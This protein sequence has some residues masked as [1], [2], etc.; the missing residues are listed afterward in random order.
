MF[1]DLQPSATIFI[2]MAFNLSTMLVQYFQKR[3]TPFGV[4]LFWR[5][6][7][8]LNW[9]ITVLQTVALPLGYGTIWN[10][11]RIAFLI[12]LERVTRLEL[13]TSTLARWRSTRWATPASWCLRS[14][15]NQRHVD[16]QSTALPTELQ[17]HIVESL[18]SPQMHYLATRNGLE[19]S[20]SSVTGWRA[21]R[22]HHRAKCGGNNRARTCDL[23]LVRQMLSQ[24]SYTPKHRRISATWFI[25]HIVWWFVKYYFTFFR[26]NFL[27]ITD[28]YFSAFFRSFSMSAGV[29]M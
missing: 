6:R 25:I 18:S 9:R 27:R 8:D 5:Y 29:K 2:R 21:N 12:F 1:T 7:P 13:A 19:P 26:R 10:K 17:R 28:A 11:E 14:E 15:S 16:F 20:T 23:L 24:L 3:R 4:R 22:L